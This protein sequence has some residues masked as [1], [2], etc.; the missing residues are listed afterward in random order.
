MQ[1]AG[2][3][4]QVQH[5]HRGCT[6]VQHACREVCTDA[7]CISIQGAGKKKPPGSKGGKDKAGQVAAH[8]NPFSFFL[9]LGE[10]E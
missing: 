4:A 6:W 7:T 8:R 9:I 5:V 10:R 3:C 1:Y 2:G